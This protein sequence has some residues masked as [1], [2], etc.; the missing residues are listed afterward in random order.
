[1]QGHGESAAPQRLGRC[2][3]RQGRLDG[4]RHLLEDRVGDGLALLP[5]DVL[6]LGDEGIHGVAP[7]A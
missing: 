3:V 7:A 1:M 6:R 4:R 5:G 2:G